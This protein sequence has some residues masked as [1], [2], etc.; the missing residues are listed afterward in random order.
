MFG[1]GI[2]MDVL[3]KV[4]EHDDCAGTDCRQDHREKPKVQ[5]QA[6]LLSVV[7]HPGECGECQVAADPECV[8]KSNSGIKF[9]LA[10]LYTGDV[11]FD[12]KALVVSRYE[13]VRQRDPKCVLVR[14][15]PGR[16][17]I[18]GPIDELVVIQVVCRHPH[19]CRVAVKDGQDVAKH[20]VPTLARKR[21]AVIV[22]VCD[23]ST[24]DTHVATD[25]AQEFDQRWVTVL[26]DD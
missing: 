17:R 12:W 1:P 6:R 8:L 22:V 19:Q 4:K 24:R 9:G 26:D 21:R 23:R 11:F 2:R 13:W 25:R 20:I 5:S 16:R 18:A 10:L 15:P 14:V 7:H 3:D